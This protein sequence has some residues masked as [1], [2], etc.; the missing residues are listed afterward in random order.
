LYFITLVHIDTLCG[1]CRE[2][3]SN[4]LVWFLL[5]IEDVRCYISSIILLCIF[6]PTVV[7]CTAV[8]CS[9]L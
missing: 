6:L 8:Y 5:N 3:T 4:L 7:W 9:E 2:V 1:A